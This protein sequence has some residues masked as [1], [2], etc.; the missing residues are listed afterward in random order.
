[1]WLSTTIRARQSPGFTLT[2]VMVSTLLMLMVTGTIFSTYRFQMFAL[3]G[4]EKQLETQQAGRGL[5]DLI[6][7][8]VRLAGYDP[9]CAKTFGG[10]AD[11]RSQLLQ[12]QFDSNADGAIGAGES[13]TYSYDTQY[14][15]IARSAGGAAVPLV[16]GL[17]ADALTFTYYDANGVVLAPGGDPPALT[18]AQRAAVRRVKVVLHLQ[19][20]TSDPL[21][22]GVVVSDL[23]SNVD[24][25]NR[26]MN[27]SV[28]C[29]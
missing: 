8:E 19:K 15:H 3:K 20:A 5:M 16:N 27:S 2:E 18:A 17:P 13:I 7:R 12:L 28:A 10:L 4:Q 29:P 21:N 26:F 11:A 1:M 6:T 9:T 24:L 23:V 22:S 25:R 14:Q